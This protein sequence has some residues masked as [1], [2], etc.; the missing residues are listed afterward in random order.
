MQMMSC[1][2]VV[3]SVDKFAVVHFLMRMHAIDDIQAEHGLCLCMQ[4]MAVEGQRNLGMLQRQDLAAAAPVKQILEAPQLFH[5]M[6]TLLQ[7]STHPANVSI[8]FSTFN[9]FLLFLH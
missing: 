5:L 8:G 2:P 6:E 4:G 3:A 1:I 9:V 7:V